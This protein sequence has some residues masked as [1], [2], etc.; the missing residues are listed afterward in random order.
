LRLLVGLGLLT[1]VMLVE[2][3]QAEEVQ[4]VVLVVVAVLVR[5]AALESVK[6]AG[7]EALV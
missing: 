1:K 2:Q 4:V 3:D 7:T 6:Q 5:S